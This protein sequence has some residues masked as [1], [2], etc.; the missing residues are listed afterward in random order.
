M[1]SLRQSAAGLLEDVYTECGEDRSAGLQRLCL[2]TAARILSFHT[3]SRLP[4][5][6]LVAAL[7]ERMYHAQESVKAL[8]AFQDLMDETAALPGRAALNN[9]LHRRKGCR[10]CETPCRYGYFSLIS[11]PDFKL[12]QRML[13]DENNKPASQQDP[14]RATWAYGSIHLWKILGIK[15]GFITPYH[16][17]N[18]TYCLLMLATAKSRFALPE[19][20]IKLYQAANQHLIQEWPQRM[21]KMHSAHDMQST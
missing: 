11:D 14:I 2:E 21:Q 18:M 6:A 10:F 17:G 20:Q 1:E 13:E 16:L 12:L 9:R 5:E 15:Q 7:G 3:A 4:D 19:E 8:Y